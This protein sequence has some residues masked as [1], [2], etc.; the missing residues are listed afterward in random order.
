M[1]N[2][3][4]HLLIISCECD[5][6]SFVCVT[7]PGD[8]INPPV[9]INGSLCMCVCETNPLLLALPYSEEGHTRRIR[10]RDSDVVDSRYSKISNENIVS[11][12]RYSLQLSPIPVPL[13]GLSVTFQECKHTTAFYYFLSQQ[14]SLSP[15]I[16]DF[17]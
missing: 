17:S 5:G 8:I 10:H 12:N 14:I 16:E 6:F 13:P 11:Y 3:F 2:N 9:L 1:Y 4:N 15:N 7:R